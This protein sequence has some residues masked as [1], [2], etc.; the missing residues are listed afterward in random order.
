MLFYMAFPLICSAMVMRLWIGGTLPFEA[1]GWWVAG[2]LIVSAL[3]F[4]IPLRNQKRSLKVL[5][6]VAV[7]GWV[8]FCLYKT[9]DWTWW[10]LSAWFL[11]CAYIT[12]VAYGPVKDLQKLR[13]VN[14]AYTIIGGYLHQLRLSDALLFVTSSFS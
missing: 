10:V 4:A 14:L 2:M 5:R 7:T 8:C 13:T 6:A 11:W 3:L 1:H 12:F 9:Q